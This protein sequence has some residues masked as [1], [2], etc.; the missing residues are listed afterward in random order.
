MVGAGRHAEANRKGPGMLL[1]IARNCVVEGCGVAAEHLCLPRLAGI[2]FENLAIHL[3]RA[4]EV[5]FLD[6]LPVPLVSFPPGEGLFPEARILLIDDEHKRGW[7][8]V[9]GALLLGRDDR[10]FDLNRNPESLQVPGPGLF[11]IDDIGDMLEIED[12]SLLWEILGIDPLDSQRARLPFDLILCDYRAKG[13]DIDLAPNL[14]S[15]TRII[16]KLQEVDPSVPIIVVTASE[17][18]KTFRQ[19]FLYGILGYYVKPY[20]LGYEETLQEYLNFCDLVNYVQESR[21][22]RDLWNLVLWLGSPECP[23]IRSFFL[24]RRMAE[25]LRDDD[26]APDGVLVA[27]LVVERLQ[28]WIGDAA[29]FIY[30]RSRGLMF[31]KTVIEDDREISIFHTVEVFTWVLYRL[32]IISDAFYLSARKESGYKRLYRNDKTFRL[33]SEICRYIRNMSMHPGTFSPGEEDLF[34]MVLCL[35]EIAFVEP[36]PARKFPRLA[37]YAATFKPFDGRKA[38]AV[39]LADCRRWDTKLSKSLRG[40]NLAADMKAFLKICEKR[41]QTSS[42]ML[43]GCYLA[44]LLHLQEQRQNPLLAG[45]L[46]GGL[47]RSL[48]PSCFGD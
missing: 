34:I 41:G 24:N 12:L 6:N 35:A 11:A 3:Q 16:K 13:E 8:T 45:F 17:N 18:F 26:I 20:N 27:E 22:W 44:L 4:Q 42:W 10:I 9:L 30:K 1:H 25:Q 7:S 47:R 28:Q 46:I 37:E 36:L 33:A 2:A 40:E 38:A 43:W 14:V 5:S 23:A 19:L 15:G 31:S 21:Y 32:S 48:P 39:F 29:R